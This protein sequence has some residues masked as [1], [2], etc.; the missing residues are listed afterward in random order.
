VRRYFDP[1]RGGGEPWIPDPA[2]EEVVDRVVVAAHESTVDRPH[3]AKGFAI[4]SIHH[5]SH[6]PGLVRVRHGSECA[7]GR[8]GAAVLRWKFTGAS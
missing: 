3:N 4:L 1:G 5:K 8:S 2:T 6:G 7:E